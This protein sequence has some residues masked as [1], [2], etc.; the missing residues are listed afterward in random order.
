M[1]NEYLKNFAV[2]VCELQGI[3]L[4]VRGPTKPV[5]FIRRCSP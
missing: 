2:G 1:F 5:T 3:K 4:A